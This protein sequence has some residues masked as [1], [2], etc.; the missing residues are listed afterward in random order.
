MRTAVPISLAFTAALASLAACGPAPLDE[1]AP[2]PARATPEEAPPTLRPR[3]YFADVRAI[4]AAEQVDLT[5]AAQR[6]LA[7]IRAAGSGTLAFGLGN[8]DL[9]DTLWI[10]SRTVVQG[11]GSGTAGASQVR[12]LTPGRP[13]FAVEPGA[14]AVVLRDLEL[15][16]LVHGPENWNGFPGMVGALAADQTT[17]IQLSGLGTRDVTISNVRLSL[18]TRGIYARAEDTDGPS[19]VRLRDVAGELD[20]VLLELDAPGARGWD[21]QG[22]DVVN[23]VADAP[24][25]P[26]ARQRGVALTRAGDVA[27]LVLSCASTAHDGGTCVDVYEHGPLS[28]RGLFSEGPAETLHVHPSALSS[29]QPIVLAHSALGNGLVVEDDVRLVSV[30][31]FYC[32]GDCPAWQGAPSRFEGEGAR[33]RVSSCG[34]F[35]GRPDQWDL[36]VFEHDP[37]FP[38]LRRQPRP[39]AFDLAAA[40]HT[41]AAATSPTARAERTYDGLPGQYF[42]APT[43]D[44]AQ[45]TA[46][47]TAALAAIDASSS[48][49]TGQL[50]LGAGTFRVSEA[51]RVRRGT[52]VQG[53]PGGATRLE[54]WSPVVN[55]VDEVALIELRTEAAVPQVAI[56]LSDL[57]LALGDTHG[58]PSTGLRIVGCSGEGCPR[59]SGYVQDLRLARLTIEGF[60]RGVFLRPEVL[61]L[62][63]LPNRTGNP[64]VDSVS[65]R[66]LRLR[67]NTV[68]LEV[69]SQNASNIHAEGLIVDDMP[70]DGLG[71]VLDGSAPFIRGLRCAA[72]DPKQPAE[73]CLRIKVGSVDVRGLSTHGLRW[74]LHAH[75][76]RGYTP[77]PMFVGDSDLREGVHLEGRVSWVSRATLFPPLATPEDAGAVARG[78]ALVLGTYRPEHPDLGGNPLPGVQS[79]LR[80]CGDDVA[81]A[82]L[83]ARGVLV[84]VCGE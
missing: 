48:L 45:D 43:G 5:T 34:D 56:G 76:S 54:L 44:V 38:G 57:V 63:G 64:M 15:R 29:D 6:G 70:P 33:A 8:Y 60:T 84:Q 80:V 55:D 22:L 19:D 26:L 52:T 23:M 17:G 36:A 31:S 28:F 14:Q 78:G 53:V 81:V 83:R 27:F 68:G 50:F 75:P 77:W 69:L 4:A 13:L 1:Q 7:R 32:S 39:C 40:E 47:L 58:V 49:G 51:L 3:P 79:R 74:A 59:G 35:A 21:V 12:L 67:G 11:L 25:F 66:D 24:P 30:A 41:F 16:S 82:G 18:F 46:A 71:L 10:P 61:E 42:V 73:A 62:A 72:A 9:T 65:L 37:V 2:S 20:N